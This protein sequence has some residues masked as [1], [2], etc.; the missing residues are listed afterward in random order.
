MVYPALLPLMRTPRLP[1]RDWTDAPT[2]LNGLVRLAER[3]N[4]VSVLVPSPIFCS[5]RSDIRILRCVIPVVC[6]INQNVMCT[7]YVVKQLSTRWYANLLNVNLN[8]MF[9]P[10]SLAII[11]LYKRKLINQLCMH[12]CLVGCTPHFCLVGCTP[13][14]CL[15]GCTPHQTKMRV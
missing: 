9:R 4:L 3:R 6:R 14:F 15:V 2:D 10:Q 1:V 13:H 8:Y 7:Q 5:F 12:F 11:R